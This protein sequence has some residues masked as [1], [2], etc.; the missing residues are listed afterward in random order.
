MNLSTFTWFTLA[1]LMIKGIYGTLFC[2]SCTSAQSGCGDPIDVRLM[3]WKICRGR[4]VIEDYCVKLIEKVAVLY[5]M[6]I[7]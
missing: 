2:Y 6:K 4:D 5:N 7:F 1:T 3:H